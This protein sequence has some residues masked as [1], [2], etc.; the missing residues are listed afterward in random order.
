MPVTFS[1]EFALSVVFDVSIG[2]Y[3]YIMKLAVVR[4]NQS[5]ASTC[6]HPSALSAAFMAP[7]Y[8]VLA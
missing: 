5:E 7:L 3:Y 6:M 2:F 4:A 8:A 1:L